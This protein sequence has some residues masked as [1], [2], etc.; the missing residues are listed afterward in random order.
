MAY[1]YFPVIW[2][3]ELINHEIQG[4]GTFYIPL[5]RHK[6]SVFN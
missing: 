5:V 6:V 4:L 1:M 3:K 2:A